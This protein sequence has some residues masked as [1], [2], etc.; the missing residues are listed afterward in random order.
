MLDSDIL[1]LI[2]QVARIR[3][4][5][6][7]NLFDKLGKSQTISR[8]ILKE[9][10]PLTVSRLGPRFPSASLRAMVYPIIQ[11][12]V[13]ERNI[14]GIT[15]HE[16]YD[17][18]RKNFPD[19]EFA[20]LQKIQETNQKNMTAFR[21]SMRKIVIPFF[22][23]DSTLNAK[24]NHVKYNTFDV[25]G[26]SPLLQDEHPTLAACWALPRPTIKGI[27]PAAPAP[28]S[29][30]QS[31]RQE[32]RGGRALCDRA[33]G[34]R[35]IARPGIH[36]HNVRLGT[37]IPDAYEINIEGRFYPSL[38]HVTLLTAARQECGRASRSSKPM[39]P[40]RMI[41][42]RLWATCTSRAR[43]N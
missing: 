4:S 6:G 23:G 38:D 17:Q 25:P 39:R 15:S 37:H 24:V 3:S 36:T 10:V 8:Q 11:T 41:E 28:A 1:F 12:V 40:S 13:V 32:E 14:A 20:L 9:A 34:S 43:E 18:L 29:R 31:R 26:G 21:H 33:S 2:V 35:P 42:L 5:A 16:E 27:S 7:E 30:R 22:E 19:G